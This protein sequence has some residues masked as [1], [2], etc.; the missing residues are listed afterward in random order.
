MFSG[1]H[2][3][4]LSKEQQIKIQNFPG[5]SSKTILDEVDILVADKPD[6]IIVHPGANIAKG[7]NSLNSVKNIVKQTSQI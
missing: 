5:S 4:G 7:I 6:C 2:E 3:H 1:I